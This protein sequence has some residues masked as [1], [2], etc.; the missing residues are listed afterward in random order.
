MRQ[1]SKDSVKSSRT[2]TPSPDRPTS[3]RR[4]F[5]KLSI[6]VSKK[7]SATSK[8]EKSRTSTEV[9]ALSPMTG[10]SP[11][12]SRESSA[13]SPNTSPSLKKRRKTL[14]TQNSIA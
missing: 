6:K 7:K 9:G 13:D 4:S 2:G 1:M 3:K 11:Q 14:T 5:P 12:K 10:P 8:N